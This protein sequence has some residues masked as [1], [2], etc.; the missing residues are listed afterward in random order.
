MADQF[1]KKAPAVYE[2][3]WGQDDPDVVITHTEVAQAIGA[4]I[5][6]TQRV[7]KKLTQAGLVM[8]SRG[9]Y[10][11][12]FKAVSIGQNPI[13][14]GQNPDRSNYPLRSSSYLE[15]DREE[16]SSVLLDSSLDEDGQGGSAPGPGSAG[17]KLWTPTSTPPLASGRRLN[18]FS[19][20]IWDLLGYFEGFV[21]PRAKRK[22]TDRNRKG[23]I[24][25]ATFLLVHDRRPVEEVAQVISWV[26]ECND[27]MLPASIKA[28]ERR[29]TRID[30]I[31]WNYDRLL[32]AM[33]MK[34]GIEAPEYP[35]RK[36]REYYDGVGFEAEDKVEILVGLWT[37]K[38][39][40]WRHV[41]ASEGDLRS[42][43]KSF[44]IAMANRQIPFEDL[45]R[46]VSALANPQ[47]EM[48]DR[49]RYVDAIQLFGRSGREWEMIR[50]QATIATLRH[51]QKTGQPL[52]D[53]VIPLQPREPIPAKKKPAPASTWQSFA[54]SL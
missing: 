29:I 2:F 41:E 54:T 49:D 40:L 12:T 11:S 14:I 5:S 15:V 16:E 36:P 45:H 46:V 39:R 7:L 13:Q 9:Q 28:K 42:W 27:G 35:D 51:Q 17:L 34:H 4:S 43:A 20:E 19:T 31:R 24:S 38:T 23:W 25:S 22:L 37:R 26:F 21:A 8:A 3:L 44:R 53:V 50:D 47:I 18:I 30:Q 10:G 6:T 48:A 32:E 52:D 33:G 1:G